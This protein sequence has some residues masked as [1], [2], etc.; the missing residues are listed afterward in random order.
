MGYKYIVKSWRWVNGRVTSSTVEFLEE[1]GALQYAR[2][3]NPAE[4]VK[5]YVDD[6]VVYSASAQPTQPQY[7]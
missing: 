4:V 2:A 1:S 3:V 6:G 5:V 7:A